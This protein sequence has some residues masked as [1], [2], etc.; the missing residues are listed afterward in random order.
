MNLADV[1]LRQLEPERIIQYLVSAGWV[2]RGDWRDT[3]S[4]WAH[5]DSPSELLVPV[6]RSF[7]DYS[8]R[9]GELLQIVQEVEDRQLAEILLEIQ[10]SDSDIVTVGSETNS[11]EPLSIDN[12][13]AFVEAARK[14]VLYSALSALNPRATHTRGRRPT[15]IQNFLQSSVH[16]GG[17][18]SER[19]VRLIV[20]RT[21]LRDGSLFDERVEDEPRTAVRVLDTAMLA[22]TSSDFFSSDRA[23]SVT[24]AV[25]QGASSDLCAAILSL[26]RATGVEGD[27]LVSLTFAPSRTVAP[28]RSQHR[29]GEESISTIEQ[30]NERLHLSQPYVTLPPAPE[31]V[32][33]P[34][35]AREL[36]GRVTVRGEVVELRR[37][38]RG[39]V[40]I[41]RVQP[42]E[43][44]ALD[45]VQ[46]TLVGDDY[47]IAVLSHLRRTILEISGTLYTTPGTGGIADLLNAE[48]T[49]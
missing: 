31:T 41:L 13:K 17:N 8:V 5:Q 45:S 40:V 11:A 37:R 38:D 9:I 3:A 1:T 27:L 36:S 23:D 30:W 35:A 32:R 43:T 4:V 15:V 16:I 18:L 14:L 39:G 42:N 29:L 12:A 26:N 25:E 24:K 46:T 47:E 10:F 28:R 6:R 2:R 22:L 48:I 49:R 19:Q 21:A 34:A 33:L 44:L 7:R 20:D